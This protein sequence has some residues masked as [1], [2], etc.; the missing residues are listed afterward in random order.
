MKKIHITD[1]QSY[2]NCARRFY[3]SQVERLELLSY[4]KPDYFVFGT[5][6]H[7]VLANHYAGKD[8]EEAFDAMESE[9]NRFLIR[10]LYDHYV[11][12][13]KVE[14]K[15]FQ[16][17][18][19]ENS[20]SLQVLDWEVIFTIDLIALFSGK[21]YT[22]IDHK[23]YDRMGEF[24]HLD[25]DFQATSYLW[26]ARKI[27]FP[28]KRFVLNVIKKSLPKYPKI[29][30]NGKI[31]TAQSQLDDTDYHMFLEAVIETGQNPEDY[32][33][34]LSA[35]EHR[36]SNTFKRIPT[37][38][39]DIELEN[40]EKELEQ[41]L[42]AIDSGFFPKH[43]TPD[44]SKCRFSFLCK[45]KDNGGNYDAVKELEFRVKEDHER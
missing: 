18:S 26:G 31:S 1:I 45:I 37:T 24:N 9:D 11:K 19:V 36:G 30:A 6:G 16:V 34:A 40:H 27:G 21:G 44:C 28:A 43:P 32:K 17:A 29:L 23:F 15:T 5:D 3:F 2:L 10:K 41:I 39:T 22:I 14:D 38:R 35:L 42:S 4:K 8:V 33:E 7:S 13:W 25:W 12:Q 20:F